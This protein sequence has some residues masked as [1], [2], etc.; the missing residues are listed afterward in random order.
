MLKFY[1]LH[2]R[3]GTCGGTG[4]PTSQRQF[5]NCYTVVIETL[6]NSQKYIMFLQYLQNLSFLAKYKLL[7]IAFLC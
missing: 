7:W 6:K 5:A 4:E 3:V 1:T 2:G